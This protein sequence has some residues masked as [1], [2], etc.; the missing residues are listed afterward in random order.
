MNRI[1]QQLATLLPPEIIRFNHRVK[2][3]DHGSVQLVNGEEL[4]AD[5]ILL[6]TEACGL[7][8][9]YVPQIKSEC[10]GTTNIYFWSEKSPH[11]G[12]WL[13]LN[14]DPKPFVNHVAI[15]SDVNKSYSPR[16]KHLISVS[17]HGIVEENT[18]AA[19]KRVRQEMRPYFG[20][21]VQHWHHLRT[22][23]LRYALPDQ[24]HVQHQIAAS[25]L[26]VKE[27]VYMCGDYLLNGSINGAMRS[28]ALAANALLHV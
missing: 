20:E 3:I 13:M 1:P 24:H 21:Q 17:C 8:H 28:G 18:Q 10:L 2:F 27:H 14:A 9:D 23:K 16:G 15:L 26:R 19:V 25:S 7:V 6:A 4:N 12:S 22:Y 5:K 11:R